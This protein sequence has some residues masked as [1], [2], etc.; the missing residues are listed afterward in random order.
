MSTYLASRT[1]SRSAINVSYM[2]H[3]STNIGVD[4]PTLATVLLKFPLSAG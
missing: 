1:E 2:A 4:R 3:N